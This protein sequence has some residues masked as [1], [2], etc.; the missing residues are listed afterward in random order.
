MTKKLQ[1]KNLAHN[2]T[3]CMRV[4]NEVTSPTGLVILQKLVNITYKSL[5]DLVPFLPTL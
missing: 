3:K 5:D 1:G 4:K 2:L